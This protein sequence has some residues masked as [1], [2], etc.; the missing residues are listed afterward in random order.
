MHFAIKC[1]RVLFNQACEKEIEIVSKCENVFENDDEI[2]VE[3]SSKNN[4][5]EKSNVV[6]VNLNVNV[7]LFELFSTLIFSHRVEF[8]KN[9]SNSKLKLRTTRI[10][11]CWDFEKRNLYF[12]SKIARRMKF[13]SSQFHEHLMHLM[14]TNLLTYLIS[15][16]DVENTTMFLKRKKIWLN[17]IMRLKWRVLR[18]RI[19]MSKQIERFQSFSKKT[20]KINF[21]VLKHIFF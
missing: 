6:T 3:K 12:W 16:N 4:D 20:R 2:S 17:E 14:R 8:S 7:E 10:K 19:D 1:R 21:D 15:E 5:I 13:R 11:S 18:R 9:S